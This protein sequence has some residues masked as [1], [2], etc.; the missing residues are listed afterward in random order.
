ME[1]K[2]ALLKNFK[3]V[4]VVISG[5]GR[6]FEKTKVVTTILVLEKSISD[7]DYEVPFVATH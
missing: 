6:W 2:K 3:I 5:Q 1:F 7:E 4:R